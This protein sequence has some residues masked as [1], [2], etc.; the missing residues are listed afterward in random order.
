MRRYRLALAGTCVIVLAFLMP[1][2]G[3]WQTLAEAA[4]I[5][6]IAHVLGFFVLALLW[7]TADAPLWGVLAGGIA[8]ALGLEVGQEVLTSTRTMSV[9]DWGLGVAGLVVGVAIG[10]RRRVVRRRKHRARR[11]R[12]EGRRSSPRRSSRRRSSS[13]RG[14]RPPAGRR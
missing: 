8:L 2:E 12:S 1:I 4:P 7:L 13:R 14:H 11:R 3:V 9:S 10:W 5:D 6:E